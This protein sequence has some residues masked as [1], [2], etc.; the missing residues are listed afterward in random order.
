MIS[1]SSALPAIN[2]E[3]EAGLLR[4]NIHKMQ[5]TIIIQKENITP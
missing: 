3:N 5:H 1:F 2:Q 4:H